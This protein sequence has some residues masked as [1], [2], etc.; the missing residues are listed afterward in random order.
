M[1]PKLKNKRGWN[2]IRSVASTLNLPDCEKISPDTKS[3]ASTLNLPDDCE[4]I[5]SDTKSLASTLDLPDDCEKISSDTKSLASTLNLPDDCEKI[6]SD[7]KKINIAF[8]CNTPRKRR[9]SSDTDDSLPD[10]EIERVRLAGSYDPNLKNIS[11]RRIV[12]ISH[13]VAQVRSLESHECHVKKTGYLAYD[14]EVHVGLNSKLFF[15]CLA[16]GLQKS[17]TTNN[18][19]TDGNIN[20][21]ATWGTLSTG[22]GHYSLEESL[23][24]L[25]IRPLDLKT[26]QKYQNEIGDSWFD[27]LTD[28]IQDAGKEEYQWAVETKNILND[29]KIGQCCVI[30]DG[31]WS[32]R[33]Y[34]H[35]YTS[36]SGVA[37]IIGAHTKKL[38]F[39]GIR[40]KYCCICAI[41]QRKHLKAPTHTCYKNWSGS[42]PAM[43]ADIIVE[44]FLKSE[45][46]HNLQYTTFIG[47]GDSSVH[48]KILENVPY[49]RKI[50][51]IECANHLTKNL[52]K[53]LHELAKESALNRKILSSSRISFIGKSCR[54]LISLHA[55][56]PNSSVQELQSDLRNVTD[57]VFG[58]HTNCRTE[59]CI[60]SGETNSENIFRKAPTETRLRILRIVGNFS[61]KSESLITDSTSNKAEQFMRQVAKF[62]SAKQTFY[63]RRNSF[64][65]RCYGAALAYQFGPSCFLKVYRKKFG[66]T[67]SVTL[68]R[69]VQ[70]R[71]KVRDINRPKRRLF[72]NCTKI[73]NSKLTDYGLQCQK[74]DLPNIEIQALIKQQIQA[75]QV[76]PE[77]AVEIEKSTRGQTENPKWFEER[78]S[79]LTASTF[80][81]ICKRRINHG[82]L[83][84]SIL[85]KPLPRLKA[86]E[87]GKI[88]ESVAIEAYVRQTKN[89]VIQCGFFVCVD[90]GFGFFGASPDGLVND[91][92][93]IEVK[94]PYSAREYTPLD[95]AN[96]LKNVYCN[97]NKDGKTPWIIN[98]TEL[99]NVILQEELLGLSINEELKVT[100][101]RG[102]Q[103]IWLQAEISEKYPGLWGIVQKHL[104]VF[105]SSYLVKKSVS[106]VTNLLKKKGAD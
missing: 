32:H 2:F 66:K 61:A 104:I 86:L 83:V 28:S 85:Y 5:S 62:N 48:T 11:G 9:D 16:C 12:N 87:Y 7:T 44:G 59:F 22:K 8:S 96:Q 100:F 55:R 31:G 52:T 69:L 17:I 65:I 58:E 30:V 34:G 27:C 75:L 70:K 80:G 99:E 6:S 35:K 71:L 64:N 78:Q 14:R 23:S 54:K 60:K 1:P 74:P 19:Q 67:P 15:K 73:S 46:M 68:K 51:K 92:K 90:K 45:K 77:T 24:L 106:A 79:R 88:N 49:S 95:A 21:L 97:V 81:E 98:E 82:K 103:K 105:P 42:S 102:Y 53:H 36:N 89:S 57:H 18:E 38:L 84:H 93:I 43:E 10:L 63:G 37:C 72:K 40:N 41:A 26:F 39:V 25:N 33:S 3:L 56:K 13:F 91:D 47:D 94:C 101:K 76:T 29:K 20:L 4:K 50:K